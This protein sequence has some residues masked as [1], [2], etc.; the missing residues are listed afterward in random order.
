LAAVL[1]AALL[2]RLGLPGLGLRAS[3]WVLLGCVPVL[4]A[5]L[6]AL[7]ARLAALHGLARLR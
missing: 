4:G 6:T 7:V 1:A 2:P 3:D 5:L